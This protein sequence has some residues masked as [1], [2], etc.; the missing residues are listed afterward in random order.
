MSVKSSTRSLST[1]DLYTV[2]KPSP[3]H[4]KLQKLDPTQL[5]PTHGWTR[6]TSNSTVDALVGLSRLDL[7]PFTSCW[8]PS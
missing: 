5:S 4:P 6:P 2:T 3:T 8:S 1:T 7:K